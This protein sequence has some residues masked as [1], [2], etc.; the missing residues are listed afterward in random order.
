MGQPRRSQEN[1][2]PSLICVV[3]DDQPVRVAMANLLESAGYGALCFD[4]A[5]SCLASG[6]LAEIDFAVFDVKLSGMD[7]F[8][9]QD[10]LA[11]LIDIPLVFV[12]GH[13]DSAME[14][15]ALDAGAIALLRK[16]ID[17]DL[18]LAHIARTLAVRG[19]G[20]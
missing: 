16:P 18:L 8:V 13:G 4:S 2:S 12:S 17:V 5:E 7:G 19:G 3:D 14:Q 10:R 15:R 1:P 11:A 20:R 9:L 6:R